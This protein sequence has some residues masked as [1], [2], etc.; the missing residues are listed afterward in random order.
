MPL[1]HDRLTGVL[2]EQTDLL[3]AV[4]RSADPAAPVPTCPGWTI[5]ALARHLAGGQRWAAE[6]VATRATEPPDDAFFRDVVRDAEQSP[7]E[8]DA[9]LAEASAAL[10]AA[11]REAGP[12]AAVWTPLG[13][14]TASFFARRFAHET[15][16]HRADA[17]LAA[18]LPYALDPDAAADT[19]DEWLE[20]GCLPAVV[21]LFPHRRALLG[22]GRTVHLHATDAPAGLDAE[23]VVDLTGAVPSW[24]RAHEKSAVAVRGP[25]T[26]LVLLVY[27]RRDVDGT[28]AEVFGDR[29]LLDAWLAA[30]AFG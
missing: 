11:L 21:E 24:R 2:T 1:D 9:A 7:A 6:V 23:W 16:V 20:L 14:G 13:P 22:P 4:V 29:E 26:E 5:G 3:R 27:R 8:L 28:A 12:D 17:T 25:L 15:A 19:L 10:A 18:G 30:N